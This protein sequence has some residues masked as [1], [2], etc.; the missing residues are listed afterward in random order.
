MSPRAQKGTVPKSA[1]HDAY[2]H[3]CVCVFKA[4]LMRRANGGRGGR[5]K[6]ALVS[7]WFVWG[8]RWCVRALGPV[9]FAGGRNKV[10][11]VCVLACLVSAVRRRRS[12]VSSV[13]VHPVCSFVGGVK[14]EGK[15][16]RDEMQQA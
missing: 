7:P 1:R 9:F 6:V 3:M 2:V 14:K 15:E 5:L 4:L 10:G 11:S 8:S 12:L 13:D 16:A